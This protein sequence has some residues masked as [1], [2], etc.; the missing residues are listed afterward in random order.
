MVDVLM[1]EPLSKKH[2]PMK[3]SLFLITHHR[4]RNLHSRL[5]H[6]D[7]IRLHHHQVILSKSP[8]IPRPLNTDHLLQDTTTTIITTIQ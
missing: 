3:F 7:S 2:T 6:L 1:P 5:P 4:R 8:E